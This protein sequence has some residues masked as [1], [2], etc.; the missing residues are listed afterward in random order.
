MYILESFLGALHHV[1]IIKEQ[2]QLR[3]LTIKYHIFI[4]HDD[5][6]VLQNKISI[7]ILSKIVVLC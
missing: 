5:R 7:D 4:S 2:K 1:L 3:E 6:R